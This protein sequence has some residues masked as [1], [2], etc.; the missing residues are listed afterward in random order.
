MMYMKLRPPD[1]PAGDMMRENQARLRDGY[2]AYVLHPLIPWS[3]YNR[4]GGCTFPHNCLCI[5]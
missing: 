1:G 4:I 5:S 3:A 2:P